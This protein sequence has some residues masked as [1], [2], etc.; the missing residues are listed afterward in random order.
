[1]K[2]DHEE[3]ESN[4]LSFHKDEYLEV[5]SNN[6]I[7]YKHELLL[8][9]DTQSSTNTKVLNNDEICL[10]IPM[11]E[12]KNSSDING[13]ISENN[14]ESKE[15]VKRELIE[16]SSNESPLNTI[17]SSAS[18][19]DNNFCINGTLHKNLKTPDKNDFWTGTFNSPTSSSK[20]SNYSPKVPSAKS[21]R[22]I[23]PR[24]LFN[25]TI[26][27]DDDIIRKAI[28]YM[29]LSKQNAILPNNFNLEVIYS[30]E[31]FDYKYS[32]IDTKTAMKYELNEI[33]FPSDL[34][35]KVL[36]TTIFTV[37]SNPIN[38]GYF[39]E[40]ELDFIYSILT[41]PPKAQM[42]LSRML[43]RKKTWHRKSNIKY[44]TDIGPD[45]KDIFEILSARSI[46]LH[47]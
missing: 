17:K 31:K 5:S 43:S 34:K 25:H 9:D 12:L 10:K 20:K 33:T 39:D 15:A 38:C 36:F 7:D 23:T 22:N 27:D 46:Y 30:S 24:K 4:I 13:D 28:E 16:N 11:K 1:M 6:M 18:N 21:M 8:I 47:I 32:P 35:S 44:E 14:I 29:N 40:K 37:F 41:L 45:L 2:I 3:I 26:D 19:N 42:L